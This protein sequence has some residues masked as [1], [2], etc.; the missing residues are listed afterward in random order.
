MKSGQGFFSNILSALLGTAAGKTASVVVLSTVLSI[1]SGATAFGLISYSGY[2]IYDSIYTNQAAFSSW[3]LSQYRPSVDEEGELSF[4]ELEK[5]NT[6]TVGWL[7]ISG[8]NIDYPVVQG[9]DDLEYASKDV[10]GN[11]SLSGSIYLTA[12]NTR[13]FTN[14]YNLIYGHHMENGAMFGDIEKYDDSDFFN[15]HQTGYLITTQGV[16]DVNVFARVSTD[17]YDSGVFSAGDRKSS[18]FPAFLNYVQSMSVQWNEGTDID[19]ITDQV[20]TYL[21]AREENIA[22]NGHFVWSKMPQYAIENGAQLLAMSTCADATTNGRQLIFATMKIRTEPLPSDVLLDDSSVPLAVF[23]HGSSAYWGLINL[24]CTILCIIV[25]LPGF[26]TRAK[27][28]K[29]NR[30]YNSADDSGDDST[31]D[32]ANDGKEEKRLTF[33]ERLRRRENIWLLVEILLTVL[34]VLVFLLT[35]NLHNRMTIL[36]RWTPLM[37]LLAALVIL[38]DIKLFAARQAEEDEDDEEDNE[39]E[40]EAGAQITQPA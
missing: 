36:D 26:R 23:G 27:Y 39:D 1:V 18:D 21:K 24:I 5:V 2:V 8:T 12:A 7:K 11:N 4:D 29:F 19:G 38:L 16:Y 25:L 20:S 10:F 35:E 17:A 22:E 31:D 30:M 6:D 40:G 32:S 3:D 37:L 13:D 28:R 34:T 9:K 15:G 14:S 33:R